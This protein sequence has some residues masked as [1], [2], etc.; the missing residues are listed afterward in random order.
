MNDTMIASEG[1]AGCRSEKGTARIVQLKPGR[2]GPCV[3]FVPGTGGRVEGFA[4]LATLL[5]TPMP[6]YAIE[7]RGVD[8]SSEPDDD[9]GEL[10]DHYVQQVKILQPLGPYFLLGHS[11]GGMVV[12]EMAQRLLAAQTQVACLILLDTLT[13]KK[14][15]PASFWLANLWSR[16]CGHIARVT[17]EPA[18]GQH[19]LLLPPLDPSPAGVA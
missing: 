11:F 7:A 5:Q 2:P 6:V 8:T 17:F 4:D 14:M 16:I 18:P 10:I 12:Y 1:R 9:I 13:P 3:F 15:W 19:C